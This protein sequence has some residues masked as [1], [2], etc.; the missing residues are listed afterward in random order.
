MNKIY[1]NLFLRNSLSDIGGI[2]TYV[3]K[4]IK[5]IIKKGD[6]AGWISNDFS[7]INPAFS[8][9]IGEKKVYLIDLQ[10]YI[11]IKTINK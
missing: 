5:E 1:C 7:K 3:Y 2:E 11:Y 9:L 6:K 4:S 8:A 10:K